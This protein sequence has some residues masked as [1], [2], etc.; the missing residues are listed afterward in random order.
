MLQPSPARQSRLALV[1]S[2]LLVVALAHIVEVGATSWAVT[3]NLPSTASV[4][5]VEHQAPTFREQ[6]PSDRTLGDQRR[7][8]AQGTTSRPF[9][10]IG[11]HI[12]TPGNAPHQSARV[13]VRSDGTWGGWTELH[14]DADHAEEGSA[15]SRVSDPFWVGEADAYEVEVPV[16][17]AAHTTVTL[18]RDLPGP[19][20]PVEGAVRSTSSGAP[21]IR[22]RASWGAAPPRVVPGRST[23][24]RFAVV[25]HSVSANSYSSTQV[26]GILRGIQ[27]YHLSQGWDDI[28]YNF[29]VDRFGTIWEARYGSAVAPVIGG[30]ALGFNSGSVGVVMLG[31][32]GS[33]LPT[34]A[35]SRAVGDVAGWKLALHGA[36]PRG[37]TAEISGGSS[38]IPADSTVTIPRIVGHRDLSATS[39]PGANLYTRLPLIRSTAGARFDSVPARHRN[40][41]A[42]DVN[43][44]GAD[45]LLWWAPRAVSEHLWR[46]TGGQAFASVG[47]PGISEEPTALLSGDFTGSGRLDMLS[48]VEGAGADRRWFGQTNGTFSAGQ[49]SIGGSYRPSVGDFNG[50]GIDD[51][52]WYGWKGKPDYIWFHEPGGAVRSRAITVNGAYT[53]VLGD[54]DGNGT[55]DILWYGPGSDPDALWLMRADG[56]P[57]NVPINISG[58]YRPIVGD[59]DGNGMDDIFWYGVGALPDSMWLMTGGG[60]YNSAKVSVGGVYEPIL[61]DFDGNGTADI[62]WYAPGAT[63]DYRWRFQVG[64]TPHSE[65]VTINGTYLARVGDFAGN[66]R[67]DIAWF[68]P[69]GSV[70]TIWYHGAGGAA[71]STRMIVNGAAT[72]M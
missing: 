67:D 29:A 43:G 55:T 23:D 40:M 4:D 19:S 59:L 20:G 21:T 70:D 2:V 8:V 60:R 31:E 28:G 24:V 56:T 10:L 68:G 14:V 5:G 26:P 48:Y 37:S 12:A 46:S 3:A 52:L 62:L 17:D 64:G 1:T 7:A 66:G 54:F 63:Q 72:S 25:H 69:G 38:T 6:S 42:G 45:D 15:P 65:R 39:C 11:V 49:V 34:E 61:G 16:T 32:F 35:A 44:D 27:R 51:I 22:S 58:T 57:Q 30:H 47:A 50:D 36:D 41:L 9:A 13:R 33:V 71:S 53:R 18:V